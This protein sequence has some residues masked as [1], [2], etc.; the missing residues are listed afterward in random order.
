MENK[1][2]DNS[3]NLTLEEQ[4]REFLSENYMYDDDG[5]TYE[6]WL[7]DGDKES[8]FYCKEWDRV[9]YECE[10]QCTICQQIK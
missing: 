2:V 7:N 1:T 3:R 9:G 10:Q 4:Y 6:E 8:N 5:P